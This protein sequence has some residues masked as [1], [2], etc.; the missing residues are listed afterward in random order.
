MPATYTLK[1][2]IE[3]AI[4]RALASNGDILASAPTVTTMGA[5]VA[6]MER[7][8][9]Y[10]PAVVVESE[11]FTNDGGA[12]GWPL[13]IG[14]VHIRAVTCRADDVSGETCDTVAQAILASIN[15]AT[16]AATVNTE[17]ANTGITYYGATCETLAVDP[18]SEDSWNESGWTVSV[19]AG[20]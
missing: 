14:Q 19:R 6:G 5:W 4:A 20:Q 16:W 18:L 7:D 11:T 1:D 8:E 10:P 13:Y 2:E 3:G 12:L 17:L 9:A 15:A